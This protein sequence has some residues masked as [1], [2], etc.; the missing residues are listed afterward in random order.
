MRK[1]IDIIG[2]VTLV[3]TLW[4]GSVA[5]AAEPDAVQPKDLAAKIREQCRAVLKQAYT[6]EEA[7]IRSGAIR[8]A[9]EALDPELIPLLEKGIE[10]FYPTTRLF[11]IQALQK[12]SEAAA[13]PAA[14]RLIGDSN[15]WVRSAALEIVADLGDRE[16]I[17]QIRK[18][19]EAP[20][21]M[22]R[23]AASYALFKLGEDDHYPEIVDAVE[24]GDTV[25]RYQAISYL[26]KIADERSIQHLVA[27][28]DSEEDDI[29]AYALKSLGEKADITMLQKLIRLSLRPN[30]SVRAKAV[31]AMGYLP[32][33]AVLDELKPF[34]ND[35]D[36]VVRLS[37]ALALHRLGKEDCRSVFAD[38]LEHDDFGVRSMT[39]RILGE[40]P[41]PNRPALLKT[42]L[43]DPVTRVR[44]AA[45]RAAGM[46][47]GAQAFQ[48]LLP[49]LEDP[50]QV[51]RAY[52]A[53]NLIRV[54][55]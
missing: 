53:G 3:L 17:P 15:I 2:A 6:S 24:G 1:R 8:A 14:R 23:L 28:L 42:A 11:A 54:M 31:R 38:L 46:M 12:V 21:R 44:T 7:F 26:G 29:V 43:S 45:V 5:F 32:P 33:I 40:T 39:A 48:L 51:I 52:A 9:G 37:A 50:Q 30:A 36:P 49:M 22:V 16:S 34:C 55:R 41:L 10:D 35:S 27:L 25:Q 47:G 19:L 20:D 13:L 18:Q 4:T